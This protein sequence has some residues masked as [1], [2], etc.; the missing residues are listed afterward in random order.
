M[1]DLD[2]RMLPDEPPKAL[3]EEIT[4]T[5]D[6]CIGGLVSENAMVP[7]PLTGMK[8][9]KVKVTCSSCKEV[10]YADKV[11]PMCSYSY[12]HGWVFGELEAQYSSTVA[13]PCCGKKAKVIKSTHIHGEN[14]EIAYKRHFAAYAIEGRFVLA[15]WRF[16]KKVTR[17]AEISYEAHIATAY[18]LEKKK[19]NLFERWWQSLEQRGNCYDNSGNIEKIFGLTAELL[20]GTTAGNSKLDVFMKG[21]GSRYPVSYL[22]LWQKKPNVE[23]L[24]MQGCGALLCDLMDIATE[25]SNKNRYFGASFKKNHRPIPK[26]E[27]IDWTQARPSKMLRLSPEEFR[28][29]IRMKW[30]ARFLAVYQ[31][32]KGLGMK[33]TEEEIELCRKLGSDEL[34][35]ILENEFPLMKTVRYLLRQKK[36]YPGDKHIDVTMLRDYWEMAIKAKFD[37]SI[38]SVKWPQRLHSAH[39][40]AVLQQKFVEEQE[41]IAKFQ[42]RFSKLEKLAWE[43]DGILIRPARTQSE[44]QCEGAFLQHCVA[45]Y[46]KRHAE[47]QT[48]IFFIRRAD[49]PDVP[50]YTLELDESTLSV[51]QNRGKCNCSRTD[52]ITE[53][54]NMWLAHIKALKNRKKRSKAA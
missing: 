7:D 26:I 34:K 51:R 41:L 14:T 3:F 23:N 18:V 52:E 15:E 5:P 27:E 47:G 16:S 2:I 19:M 1:D 30:D 39:D 8:E 50:W 33:L 32:V 24:V 44:L 54:E 29:C 38:E 9:E 20:E 35:K 13:C 25:R 31:T 45:S 48:A 28:M 37:L 12:A 10:F 21:K 40:Q 46:A 49:A 36:K 53:F 11:I 43:K 6:F 17:K 22:R 4:N 42:S